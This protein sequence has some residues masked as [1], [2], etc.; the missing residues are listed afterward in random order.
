MGYSVFK[1]GALYL[2]DK[3]QLIPKQLTGNGDVPSYDGKAAIS[4]GSSKKWKG[5][6][7]VKPNGR[8]LFIADHVLLNKISWE[9]LDKNGFVEG[10]S[11]LIN[12]QYFR[13]R[14]LQIGKDEYTLNEWDATLDET[15]KDNTLWHW[16]RMFFWGVDISA[17]N[18]S[19]RAVR[20]YSSAHTW[21][22]DTTT[23][24]GLSVG[25]RPALEPLPSNSPILN[26]NLD[27]VNFQLASLPEE[28]GFRPVLQPT[29]ENVFGDI[30]VGG[31]VRMY[32]FLE[33]GKPI[34]FGATVKDISKLTLT[35]RYYGDEFLIPW[36]ISN[37]IAIASQSMKQQI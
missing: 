10:K 30:P 28:N 27:E 12:G 4:I 25:F 2:G 14:L 3:I 34:H 16:N 26:I 7:W 31:K 29:Q 1:F 17:H 20:G 24:R 23:S 36:V 13:C 37:G 5:I 32:T 35:D 18:V 6:T 21:A 9:D 15:G 22:H 33:G 19:Y 8:S 11:M